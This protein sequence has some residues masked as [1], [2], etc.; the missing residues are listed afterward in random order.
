MV[1]KVHDG[2]NPPLL[3]VSFFRVGD[4]IKSRVSPFEGCQIPGLHPMQEG[5]ESDA[6]A[7]DQ[8]GYCG[9]PPGQP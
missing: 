1:I 2:R 5:L 3:V 6:L 7:S 4:S 8:S 9:L